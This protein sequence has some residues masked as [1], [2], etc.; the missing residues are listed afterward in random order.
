MA[1]LS[2]LYSWKYLPLKIYFCDELSFPF[3]FL[4]VWN[5][6]IATIYYNMALFAKIAWQMKVCRLCIYPNLIVGALIGIY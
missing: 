5:T 3:F 4:G 6:I 2:Q 1:L